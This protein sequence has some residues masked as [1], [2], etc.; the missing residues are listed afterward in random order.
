MHGIPNALA[1]VMLNDEELK[2][3]AEHGL[4]GAIIC[5]ESGSIVESTSDDLEVFGNILGYVEHLANMIGDSFGL[6]GVEQV[7]LKSSQTVGICVPRDGVTLGLLCKNTAKVG[8]ILTHF[9]GF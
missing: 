3:L 8:K 1:R 5:N 4:L 6:D 7:H 2:T 9:E